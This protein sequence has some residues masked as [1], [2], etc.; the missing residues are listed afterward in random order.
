M[1]S[2]IFQE[3]DH[4][5]THIRYPFTDSSS[6]TNNAGDRIPDELFIGAVIYSPIAAQTVYISKI[7]RTN[8]IITLTISANNIG[9]I[10]TAVFDAETP[11]EETAVPPPPPLPP[12]PELPPSLVGAVYVKLVFP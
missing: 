11:P 4:Q 12:P 5:N 7:N 10:A 8:F 1:S 2:E 3:W 9:A 6:G